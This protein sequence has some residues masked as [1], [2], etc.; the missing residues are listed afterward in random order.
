MSPGLKLVISTKVQFSKK[1]KTDT[2][3]RG[4]KHS[5]GGGGG[6]EKW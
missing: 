4:S 2:S 6:G 5:G 1:I 3:V